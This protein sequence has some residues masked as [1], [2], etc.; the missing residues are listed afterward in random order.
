MN[1]HGLFGNT[2]EPALSDRNYLQGM[3]SLD[4]MSTPTQAE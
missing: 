1:G 2:F 3:V 4:V